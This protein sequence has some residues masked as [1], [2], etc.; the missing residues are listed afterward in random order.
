MCT[1]IGDICDPN[2]IGFSNVELPPQ[3]MWGQ[4]R[5][6]SAAH[7]WTIQ[8][9]AADAEPQ[10][11]RPD[12]HAPTPVLPFRSGILPYIASYS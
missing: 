4:H 8:A 10:L 7:S 2:Q 3:M 6:S 5:S 9:V 1:D 12:A 11:R